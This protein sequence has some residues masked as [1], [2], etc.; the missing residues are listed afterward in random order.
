MFFSLCAQPTNTIPASA[1][2]A[3]N[4]FMNYVLSVSS[5]QLLLLRFRAVAVRAAE[6]AVGIRAGT[7]GRIAR[8]TRIAARALIRTAAHV[9]LFVR[10]ADKYHSSERDQCHQFFH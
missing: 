7:A 9:L 5:W 10:A 1:I 3:V 8:T 4:F 2:S 6:A